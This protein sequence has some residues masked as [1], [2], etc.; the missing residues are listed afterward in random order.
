MLTLSPDTPNKFLLFAN[1]LPGSVDELQFGFEYYDH[2]E[3]TSVAATVVEQFGGVLCVE[4][5]ALAA[6]QSGQAV[7]VVKRGA[8]VLYRDEIRFSAPS[9]DA[10]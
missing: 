1:L 10:Q 3:P 4:M 7:L 5:D 6:P 9:D 2:H 8:D